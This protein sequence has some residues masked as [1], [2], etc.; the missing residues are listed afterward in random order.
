MAY[1]NFNKVYVLRNYKKIS[2]LSETK[3]QKKKNDKGFYAES[4]ELLGCYW[5][6]KGHVFAECSP[7]CKGSLLN[8]N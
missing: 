5:K 8:V 7:Q 4:S 6:V 2:I 1:R 3:N